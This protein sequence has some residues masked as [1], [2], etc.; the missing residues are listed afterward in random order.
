MNKNFLLLIIFITFFTGCISQN[1]VKEVFQTNKAIEISND[2]KKILSFLNEYKIKLDKRN[3]KHYNKVLEKAIYNQINSGKTSVVLKDFQGKKLKNF[4]QYLDLAFD[5][6]G[7]VYRN[8]YLI[9]GIFYMIYDAYLMDGHHK[10]SA[11]NYDKDLLTKLY[12]NLH[13]LRWKVRTTKDINGNYLF[14]TWQNNW[15]VE[16]MKKG[17]SNLNE[18]KNLEAIKNN[19]ESLLS[20]SNFS[21]EVLLSLMI[22]RVE[23]TLNDIGAEPSEIT[24]DTI[25]SLV[26][27]I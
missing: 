19:K 11:L 25:A 2:Y 10:F 17:L 18:L 5:K 26:F 15:Q 14:L 8:D 16:Y 3:P 7:V 21:F 9:L 23:N 20:H 22:N 12:K 1:R 4:K 6:K 24:F 13:I 27:I